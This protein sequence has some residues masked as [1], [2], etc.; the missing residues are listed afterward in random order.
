MTRYTLLN[1]FE[2]DGDKTRFL[3]YGV[4]DLTQIVVFPKFV[5]FP[6]AIR[7][8]DIE[9]LCIYGGSAVFSNVRNQKRITKVAIERYFRPK[10][11]DEAVATNNVYLLLNEYWSTFAF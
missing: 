3:I 4:G 2:G 8:L 5:T 10:E 6:Q 1:F 11:S 9:G 7:E